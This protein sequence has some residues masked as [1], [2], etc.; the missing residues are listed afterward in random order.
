LDFTDHL[1]KF[2][3][4]FGTMYCYENY[5]IGNLNP[6][7]KVTNAIAIQMLDDI[8]KH[9]GNGKIVFISNREFGNEVDPKVYKLVN[10]ATMIGIA[11]VGSTQ[12]QK[13]QAAIEQSL[14]GGSF[15][16]FNTLESAVV[17]AKSFTLD[18]N[19][20]STSE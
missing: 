20:L 13:I 19:L 15:G 14:Y 7:V 17:W 4:A 3:Y 16:Y 6:E 18:S 10:P 1:K 9:F 11:I 5:V 12:E 8:N 2:E